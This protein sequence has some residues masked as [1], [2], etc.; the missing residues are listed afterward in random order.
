MQIR[1]CGSAGRGTKI[2]RDT[3]ASE[4]LRR[5]EARRS[6]EKAG[7]DTGHKHGAPN[8]GRK[9][10]QT[11]KQREYGGRGESATAIRLRRRH[12]TRER[13]VHGGDAPKVCV[14]AVAVSVYVVKTTEFTENPANSPAN[15]RRCGLFR[16]SGTATLS[17]RT[18]DASADILLCR[19]IH[20][21]FILHGRY[22]GEFPTVHTILRQLLMWERTV[23]PHNSDQPHVT[24]AT[25]ECPL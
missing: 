22:R 14:F 7:T 12:L 25:P 1:G 5:H 9:T 24:I 6:Q 19:Q 21:D 4:M 11:L 16:A 10:A 8:K 20:G 3:G 18:G 13:T 15:D 17:P 2:R 23:F